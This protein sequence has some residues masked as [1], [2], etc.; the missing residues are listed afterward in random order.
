MLY[1]P[2]F[3]FQ[4]F[5]ELCPWAGNFTSASQVF[6]PFRW[7]KIAREG[8]SWYS[9]LPNGCLEFGV[10]YFSSPRLIRLL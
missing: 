3:G 9:L 4:S 2:V 7:E 1:S 10:Q 8:K 6:T 5:G